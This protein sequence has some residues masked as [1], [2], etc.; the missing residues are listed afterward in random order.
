LPADLDLLL[1][2][3]AAKLGMSVMARAKVEEE[4]RRVAR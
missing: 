4:A 2:T 3:A 1:L